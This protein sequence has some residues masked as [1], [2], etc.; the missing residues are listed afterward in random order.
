MMSYELDISVFT[1]ALL[2][3]SIIY[4]TYKKSNPGRC[5]N[6][7]NGEFIHLR[8]T[9][10]KIDENECGNEYNTINDVFVALSHHNI[11]FKG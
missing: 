6:S 7:D 9:E 3:F 10:N 2:A 11:S 8:Q 5:Y 4:K 1:S